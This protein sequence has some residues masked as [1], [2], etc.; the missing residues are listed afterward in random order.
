LAKIP[1][2]KQNEVVFLNKK[3]IKVGISFF[4]G[5]KKKKFLSEI[6]HNLENKEKL[7]QGDYHFDKLRKDLY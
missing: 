5:K 4:Y 2:H 1:F 7:D 3:N 6:N